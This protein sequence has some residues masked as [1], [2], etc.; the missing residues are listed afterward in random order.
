MKNKTSQIR[1]ISSDI[2][3]ILKISQTKGWKDLSALSII[4]IIYFSSIFYSFIYQDK[5]NSFEGIYTFSVTVR[6]PICSDIVSAL[7]YL[8]SQ[9]IVTLHNLQYSLT[10]NTIQKDIQAMPL[11]KEKY[12]WFQTIISIL[13]MY[14]ESKIYDLIFRDPEYTTNRKRNDNS[15][16]INSKNETLKYLN[17]FKELFE[18]N[19]DKKYKQAMTHEKYLELYLDYVFSKVLKGTLLDDLK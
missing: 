7:N 18:A 12:T 14:G 2:I 9:S 3:S 5:N 13:V 6:G 10:S 8:D 15:I 4:R 16:K 1:D 11:Y 17:K 19:M